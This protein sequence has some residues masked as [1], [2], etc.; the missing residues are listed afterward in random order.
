[1]FLDEYSRKSWIL[2][3][4]SK[5]EFF[6]AF[7]LLLPRA[8]TSGEKLGCLQ[9]DDGGEFISAA[10]KGFCDE[11]S[12][13]IGYAAPYIHEENGIAERYWRTLTTMKDSLL[14]DSGLPV[15]FWADA[16]D[17]ANYLCNRLPTK[18]SGSRPA[19][20]PE[21]A[22]TSTRQN[23]EHIRIFGSRVNTFIPNEK[24]T[25]SDVRK[26]W[27]GIFICYIGTSKHL[28]VWAPRT[29]QVLIA[30]KPVV[31][32]GK[33]GADLL[34]EHPLPHPEKP[35]RPQTG[36]P[37][38]RSRPCKI[39]VA[40]SFEKDKAGKRTH[41]EDVATKDGDVDELAKAITKWRRTHPPLYLMPRIDLGRTSGENP[42]VRDGLVSPACYEVAK[43]VTETSNKVRELNIY[44]VAI[45]NPIHDNRR[46]GAVDEEL[47][48]LDTHQTWCYTLLPNN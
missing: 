27:K 1:M 40:K 28:R 12:I 45:N 5:D 44:D 41:T 7:K 19:F 2:L 22:W 24:H 38:L 9:I 32:K 31:N 10:L 33:R 43:I 8:E 48:N 18:R 17:T 30:S 36:E 23:L 34:V 11:R 16:M 13:T 37:K 15:N 14:V 25:K 6:D 42:P 4:Q 29:H 26:T 46:R 47:W 39:P 21:E 20:I 3:F 35:L